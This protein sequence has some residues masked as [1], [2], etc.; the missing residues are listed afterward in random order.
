VI[1]HDKPDDLTS[2][3]T[4]NAGGRIGCGVIVIQGDGTVPITKR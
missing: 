2:Q 4:G 1:I 3:P